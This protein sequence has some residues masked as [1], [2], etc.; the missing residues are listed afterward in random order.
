LQEKYK[1]ISFSKFKFQ[2][3]MMVV[4]GKYKN[5]I[6]KLWHDFPRLA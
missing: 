4:V 5:L 1:K 3:I 6:N 2:N